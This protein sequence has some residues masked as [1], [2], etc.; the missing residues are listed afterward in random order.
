MH[1]WVSLNGSS[2]TPMDRFHPLP[3]QDRPDPRKSRRDRRD[4]GAEVDKVD[5]SE[6]L[7]QLWGC[8][9]SGILP[10]LRPLT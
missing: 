9:P 5:V 1:I 6:M 2:K 4:R 8:E 7:S 10:T 3:L